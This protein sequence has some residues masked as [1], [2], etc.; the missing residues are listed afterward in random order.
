MKQSYKFSRFTFHVSLLSFF[1]FSFSLASAQ[2]KPNTQTQPNATTQT[3][4]PIPAAYSGTMPLN[5]IRTWDAEKPFSSDTVLTSNVRN[6]GEVKQ[7]TQY[8]DGIGRPVQTVIEDMSPKGFDLVAPMLFDGLGREQFKYLSYTSTTNDGNFKSDPFNEQNNFLKGVYNPTNDANGEKFF[9]SKTTYESSP[10][11]RVTNAYAL[12]NSWAGNA[13]GVTKQ[14]RLNYASDSVIIWNISSTIGMNP[15]MGGYYTAGQ[16]DKIITTDERGNQVVEYKDKEGKLLL[17]KVQV[18]SGAGLY[19]GHTGWYCTYYIYDDLNSLRFVLQPK[20]VDFLKGNSWAFDA[21]TYA[22]SSISKELCFSYEYDDRKRM[23]VKRVPGAGELWMVYDARDRLVMTQDSVLRAAGKWLYTDYDSLNRPVVTGAWTVSGDRAYHQNLAGS[24]VTYPTPA[25]SYT[26]LTQTYYD[27][28]SWVSSSGSGLSSGLITTYNSNSSYFYTPD[29]NNFPY[30]RSITA[31]SSTRGMVTGAKTNVLNTTTY[32]YSVSFYDDRARNIQTQSTNYTGGKDTATIQY[33]FNGKV[34]RTLVAH[35]KGG[36]NPQS[37]LVLTRN[38]YDLAGRATAITKKVG[39]SFEDTVAVNTYNELGQLQKKNLGKTRNNLTNYA[40]TVNPLDSLTYTYNIRGWLNGINK[41]Y[42]RGT[43]TNWF[44]EELSYDYGFTSSQLNGNIAG[45]RWRSRD[46]GYQ[47]AY[48]FTYDAVNR[49]TKADFTQNAGNVWDVSAGIDYSL[50]S[51]SYDQNGNIL[52]MNQMGL[53]LNTSVLID[54]LVY[55]YYNGGNSNRLNYVTDKVNDT[56]TVLGDFKEY[57]TGTTPDYTYD[58]NGNIRADNNKRLSNILYN[59]LN[60][61]QSVTQTGNGII[62]YT[63]DAAGNK[64]RKV[65]TDTVGVDK[66]TRTDYAGLFSYVNDTL[67]YIMQEEGRIRPK[68]VNKSD[69]MYYDFFER[70]HLGNTRIVLTDE[71]QQDTYPAATLE[72]NTNAYN[73]EK[74]YYSV[75]T[76]DTISVNRIAS[77]SATT[78]NNYANNNGNPPYN[79]NPYANTTATSNIVYKLNG[80]NGDKTG[81]GITLK[82]MT[83]D[84]VDIYGKSFWHSNGVNPTNNYLITSALSTF[85]NAFAG[86]SAVAGSGHGATAAALNGSTA[87]TSGL[88][89]WLGGV[90]NPTNTAVPKAYI[91]WILFD[92][93]FKPVASNSSFDLINTVSDA[94]KNHHS[95]VSISKSGYLYVYCSNES[96]IDVF[97]DNLQLIHTRGPLLETTQYNSFGLTLA[98]ISS[99]AAG[100]LDNK[101]EYNG[102][103][104]Q[105]KEFRDGSGLDMYDY[106]ARMYDAQIGRWET[107]DPISD[108][109]RRWSPYNFVFNNP[110][111]NIDPDGLEASDVLYEGEM[112]FMNKEHGTEEAYVDEAKEAV[113]KDDASN[114]FPILIGTKGSLGGEDSEAG[115]NGNSSGIELGDLGSKTDA[116]LF[117][118][119]YSLFDYYSHGEMKDM[120]KYMVDRYKQN[121]KGNYENSL[122]NYYASQS[123]Y[124]KEFKNDILSLVKWGLKIRNGDIANFTISILERPNFDEKFSGLG[125]TV[126]GIQ[127]AQVFLNDYNID[128]YGNYNLTL[129]MKLYDDFGLSRDDVIY[130]QNKKVMGMHVPQLDGL[131]A[132]WILQHQ[133]NY[134]PYVTVVSTTEA[135]QNNINN[136]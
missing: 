52:T 123:E 56:A 135:Y 95:T 81:L 117:A 120:A 99:R 96:N 31:T 133:R 116:E 48:G 85:I 105:E 86:T 34:L 68:T 82:V 18:A 58:G 64:L 126:H 19:T 14:Y 74:A 44:G 41:N 112:S 109:M 13:M 83:G 12:G 89:G 3:L 33:S 10:L 45:I 39:N 72:N 88:N 51:M 110:L 134:Q 55:G 98:G 62:V 26:V 61:T 122:L 107:V 111:R 36:T 129:G 46:D 35:G 84:V 67:Q 6:V 21:A 94:I 40:Y 17:K 63:Y 128:K 75:N 57:N 106:G 32:L 76:A 15:L 37:Y 22:S 73:T 23:I 53:K 28:Y 80:A 2:V 92:E 131:K 119:M 16:L 20:A 97:F 93:Q 7:T 54:S 27:D 78:G 79:N 70:D 43:G 121:A 25:S 77:W 127:K 60:L 30:P 59:L 29:D 47:R 5:F 100:K 118:M 49:L 124:Y 91:N 38:F 113:D 4:N 103:E 130:F 11:N 71:K 90:P 125:I 102:K 65:T 9:Y 1:L 108:K 69:T 136:E 8:F 50:H 24:S 115:T 114:D 104:K 66:V 42:A 101:F 132:W 87:T